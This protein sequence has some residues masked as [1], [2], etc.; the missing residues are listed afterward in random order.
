MSKTTIRNLIISS[1]FLLVTA[2]AFVFVL[3]ITERENSILTEQLIALEKKRAQESQHLKLKRIAVESEADRELLG[4]YFLSQESDSIDFLNKVESL[5]PQFDITLK[6]DSLKKDTDKR[7]KE[8]W[9]T[10]QFS[11]NGTYQ[12]VSD[13][14][15]ILENLPYIA[16]VTQ[17][18]LEAG[19]E[20]DW[21]ATVNMRIN[22]YTYDD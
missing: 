10:A 13:F 8:E 11:F 17:V 1:I 21:A 19:S 14:V 4:G 18:S 12:N 15:Q 22:L 7:T 6:T 9:L 20:N 16:E 5:A 2:T 3:Y